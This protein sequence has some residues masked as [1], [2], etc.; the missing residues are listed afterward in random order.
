MLLDNKP[1]QNDHL[2]DSKFGMVKTV[3][4]CLHRLINLT[5]NIKVHTKSFL[6]VIQT[7]YHSFKI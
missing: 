2:T 3:F 5:N 1:V 6:Q 4:F 7:K